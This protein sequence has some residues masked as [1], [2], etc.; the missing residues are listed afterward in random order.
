VAASVQGGL[1]ATIDPYLYT[2]HV[3]IRSDKDPEEAL[4]ILDKEMD[5]ILAQP[6]E[7]RELNKAIKQAKALFA[8]S[9]ESIT[10]QGFWMGFTEM[11]DEYSWL[12]TYLDRIS[13]VT[14]ESAWDCARRY[15]AR[16]NRIV[17]MYHPK[18]KA[19]RA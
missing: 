1:A 7:E 14:P 19:E 15:L 6:I 13:Q 8:Y 10:N 11:F 9:S 3:T 17:G 16:S 2:I 18:E 4:A 5:Q 12:E